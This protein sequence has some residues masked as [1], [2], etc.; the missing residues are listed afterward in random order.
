MTD[1]EEKKIFARNLRH[2]I[3]LSGKM[4]IDVA[5]DLGIAIQTLN[6]WCNG[7]S[8]PKMGKVQRLADYFG[9]GKSDLLDDKTSGSYTLDLTEE[10]HQL[11]MKLRSSDTKTD[12][13]LRIMAYASMLN[14]HG[15]DDLIRYAKLISNSEDYKKEE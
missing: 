13:A 8:I 3:Q 14:G 11:I 2:Y 10:E 6:G 15:K 9:I 1:N 7:V 12:Q 4:Q 5:K